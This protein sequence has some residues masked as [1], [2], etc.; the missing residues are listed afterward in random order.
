[1]ATFDD[2]LF[3]DLIPRAAP[4]G[5]PAAAKA[6]SPVEDDDLFGDLVPRAAV[7]PGAPIPSAVL[8]DDGYDYL[9]VQNEAARQTLLNPGMPISELGMLDGRPIA[10]PAFEVTPDAATLTGNRY[11]S[12]SFTSE[13]GTVN[14]VRG[15]L[16]P[17]ERLVRGGALQGDESQRRFEA[18]EQI[19]TVR[20]TDAWGNAVSGFNSGMASLGAAV[21]GVPEYVQARGRV[22]ETTPFMDRLASAF[23]SLADGSFQIGNTDHSMELGTGIASTLGD[24][25]QRGERG[26]ER[27]LP[28]GTT[29]QR[30]RDTIARDRLPQILGEYADD[31]KRY[32]LGADVEALASAETAADAFALIRQNPAT[33]GRL[34]AGYGAQSV[35]RMVPQ[36]G[37]ATL[38]G[39]V[40]GPGGVVAGG[41]AGGSMTGFMAQ[42]VPGI[43]EYLAENNLRPDQLNQPEVLRAALEYAEAQSLR[44]GAVEG[45]LGALSATP[46]GFGRGLLTRELTNSLVS[47]PLSQ[48]VL[49]AVGDNLATGAPLNAGSLLT[50]V[51]TEG[52]FGP[53]EA[54]PATVSRVVEDRALRRLG[55]TPAQIEAM[56]AGQRRIIVRDKVAATAKPAQDGAGAPPPAAAPA[57]APDTLGEAPAPAQATTAA[58]GPKAEALRAWRETIDSI[59]AGVAVPADSPLADRMKRQRADAIAAG[60]TEDE[61]NAT[62]PSQAAP[63]PETRPDPAL[64]DDVFGAFDGVEPPPPAPAAPTEQ[65]AQARGGTPPEGAGGTQPTPAPAPTAGLRAATDD[66]DLAPMGAARLAGVQVASTQDDV[67]AEI[68]ARTGDLTGAEGIYDPDTG[69]VYII[70]EFLGSPEKTGMTRAQRKRWV[71]AHER[72]GGHAGIRG[73]A[74]SGEGRSMAEVL[75]EAEAN[76]TVRAIVDV[77][78]AAEQGRSEAERANRYVLLEEALAE[79]GAARTTADWDHIERR[80][81]VKVPHAQRE[82]IRG[83]IARLLDRMRVAFGLEGVNDAAI[84]QIL[85]DA[86][87]YADSGRVA[88]TSRRAQAAARGEVMPTPAPAAVLGDAPQ[89][90]AAAAPAAAGPAVAPPAPPEAE[91]LGG[92]A[93][94]PAPV[95]AAPP[96]PAPTPKPRAPRRKAKPAPTAA[97][98]PELLKL[99]KR[100]QAARIGGVWYVREKIAGQWQDWVKKP[101]F[102][103]AV[104]RAAG[105][106]PSTGRVTIPGRGTVQV[107]SADPRAA[108]DRQVT[109]DLYHYLSGVGLN[110]EA[111]AREGVDPAQFTL[112]HGISYLFRKEGGLTPSELR[113]ALQQDGFLPQD[114]PNAPPV[115]GDDDAIDLVFRALAGERVWPI[116]GSADAERMAFEDA[117][118][119]DDDED[120]VHVPGFDDEPAD[121]QAYEDVPFSRAPARAPSGDLFAKPTPREEVDAERKARDAKRDGKTGTGRTDMASGEGELFAG[122]RPQQ[123]DLDG[124]VEASFDLFAP[125]RGQRAA[126]TVP[127]SEQL[128]PDGETGLDLDHRPDYTPELGKKGAN[129]VDGMLR[130]YGGSVVADAIARDFREKGTAELLG[131]KIGGRVGSTALP[132]SNLVLDLYQ[133]VSPSGTVLHTSDSKA[134]AEGWIRHN[135]H[136][137]FAVG[138]TVRELDLSEYAAPSLDLTGSMVDAALD[139]LPLFSRAPD[140]R[141]TNAAPEAGTGERLRADLRAAVED[142]GSLATAMSPVRA[143]RAVNRLRALVFDSMRSRARTLEAKHPDAP[144]L[145]KLFDLYFEA[146]GHDRLVPETIPQATEARRN[147]FLNRVERHLEAAGLHESKMTP[148]Q[149]RHL[150]NALLGVDANVPPNIRG[151]AE[152]IRREMDVQREDAVAA[153]IEVGEVTDIGYLTRLYDDAK[154]EADES[155]FLRDAGNHYRTHEWR[156]EVGAPR[157]VLYGDGTFARFVAALRRAAAGNPRLTSRMDT[158]RSLAQSYRSTSNTHGE[159]AAIRAIVA[160]VYDEVAADWS[161]RKATAWLHAIRTPDISRGFNGLLES[162]APVTRTRALAGAADVTLQDWM[163]TDVREILRA[164]ADTMASKIEEAK[165]V[166]TT[167]EILQGLLDDAAAQG[168]PKADLEEATRI[169]DTVTG[170]RQ[171]ANPTAQTA[172]EVASAWTYLTLLGR[173]LFASLYESTA[174]AMRTGQLRHVL[175]PLLML[176]R[177][178]SAPL[179]NT[180]AR[181]LRRLAVDIGVNGHRAVEDAMMATHVGGEV[182]NKLVNRITTAFFRGIWLTRLTEAQRAYGVGASVGYLKSL[183]R[184]YQKVQR[185]ASANPGALVRS[186]ASI[187]FNELGIADHD[188]FSDWILRQPAIPK[189]SELFDQDGRP[190]PMGNAFMVAARRLVKGSIQEVRPEHR[191]VWQNSPGGRVFGAIMGYSMASYANLLRREFD[192]SNTLRRNFGAGASAKRGAV[193]LASIAGIYANALIISTLREALFNQARFEDKDYE[194]IRRELAWLAAQRTFG[195]GAVDLIIQMV[196]GLKYR[197][198][199]TETAAGATIGTAAQDA[200]RIARALSG[201]N[202]PATDTDEYRAM[203]AVYRSIITPALNVILSRV[204]GLSGIAIP[205]ASGSN[206]RKRF[207]GLFYTEPDAKTDLDD[208]YTAAT[209]QITGAKAALEDRM[210]AMPRKQWAAELQKIKAEYPTLLQGLTLDRYVVNEAN[211]K[212]GRAGAVKTDDQGNP[213]LKFVAPKGG[214]G[215]LYG[216]LEGYPAGNG[217]T[218]KGLRDEVGDLTKAI[219]NIRRERDIRVDALAALVGDIPGESADAVRARAAAGEGGKLAGSR[220]RNAVLDDLLADRRKVKRAV[221]KLVEASEKGKVE[222]GQ[223]KRTLEDVRRGR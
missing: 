199:I 56:P 15:D 108:K 98:A 28:G 82:T 121:P 220:L 183:A 25:F 188:A 79:L 86:G 197:K 91:I 113:E 143:A 222:R 173:G 202:N 191:T 34:V 6:A 131:Q 139:G 157:D 218:T 192:L 203:E 142:L 207:A 187:Y 133:V 135:G 84:L 194:E 201:E 209:K 170:S 159:S 96:A 24:L 162:G 38:G 40:G 105:Y 116:D 59:P 3:G 18:G 81:K 103:G 92:P 165:R 101:K 219:N 54:G 88:G 107:G 55:Y 153:G 109:G 97:Q 184:Q 94:A 29:A 75:G 172:V 74:V 181:D 161:R 189:A 206:M 72:A 213:K 200:Q 14:G 211:R 93:P 68:R 13:V 124:G 26:L 76:P 171:F 145:R 147:V 90:P 99:G 177:T 35:P 122:R 132:P 32:P 37:G 23:P 49:G 123:A 168:V 120:E 127:P 22:A 212:L 144:S 111:W 47:Q 160:E 50:N 112:R 39:L 80:Y 125:T 140:L 156:R 210:G 137:A 128:K 152:L 44:S 163:R 89:A 138:A 179:G 7:A 70:E 126:P 52:M 48:G 64:G 100:K 73:A 46:L 196:T 155:G 66:A 58:H 221:V 2:E 158:L 85:R 217:K 150:R 67:P 106:L 57:V 95:V 149:N 167:P 195:L 146:P 118:R 104:A 130:R 102:D 17:G 12:P 78:G 114:Q 115:V 166:G 53:V 33:L 30:S 61:L 69:Q 193:A 117:R 141:S 204:P 186:P 154:I 4:T 129:A 198:S 151:A 1:M 71:A 51:S 176:G 178:L 8:G 11:V 31:M 214:E 83:M 148:A 62:T 63:D 45:A 43:T 169:L 77:M 216:E 185:V 119:P 223:G 5:Q 205:A 87:R 16:S 60:A 20:P 190:T 42:L 136:H 65:P 134:D 208:D 21:E 36:I 180:T 110:R 164:Y 9:A 215:S 175:S 41:Y 182:T 174:Y 27:M 10:Q 19:A